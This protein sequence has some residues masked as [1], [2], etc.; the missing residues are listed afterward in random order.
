[1]N[2]GE[3]GETK[4]DRSLNLFDGDR[5]IP[6]FE[7]A[8]KDFVQVLAIDDSQVVGDGMSLLESERESLRLI[9]GE[10]FEGVDSKML[11]HPFRRS[12]VAL[13]PIA[14]RFAKDIFDLGF[15]DSVVS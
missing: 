12:F 9:P 10:V 6:S 15:A 1:M 5:H 3:C 2:L 8:G 4:T 13:E 11:L 7:I 14:D